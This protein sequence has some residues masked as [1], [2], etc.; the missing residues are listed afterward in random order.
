LEKAVDPKRHL[1][2]LRSDPPRTNE[3]LMCAHRDGD[4]GA[5]DELVLRWRGPVWRFLRRMIA[6]D[7]RAEELLSD[8]FLKVHR[9]APRYEP[10][11]KFSTWLFTVAYR[12]ALN[13]RE[14][15]AHR[16]DI[17]SGGPGDFDMADPG[18]GPEQDLR[19]Q[20]SLRAVDR[21]L[22]ALPAAHRAAFL[23]YYGEELSCAEIAEA[24]AAS[25]EEIKGQL[26]YARKLL[27]QRLSEA[28]IEESTP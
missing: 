14:R 25:P 23:L 3:A 9:A 4:D 21:E 7:A 28:D 19:M 16:L 10:K 17:A 22:R 8:V 24:L 27:R 13:A 15:T 1:R 12:A 2:L 18:P 5:F 11:S 20:R 6:D 26:A